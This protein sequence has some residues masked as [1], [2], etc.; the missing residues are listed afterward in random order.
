MLSA[1]TVEILKRLSSAELK[2]FGDFINSPYHNSTASLEKIYKIV[3]KAR[4]DYSSPALEYKN[5]WKKMFPHEEYKEKRIKNLYADFS[6]ILKKFIGYEEIAN[7]SYELDL[8]TAESLSAK[9]LFDASAKFIKKSIAKHDTGLITDHIKLLYNQ[10]INIIQRDNFQHA[11]AETKEQDYRNVL[12]VISESMI[13]RFLRI[14][15]TEAYSIAT[16]EAISSEKGIMIVDA[17]LNVFDMEKFLETLKRE[18]HKY[19][20]YLKINYMLYYHMKSDI[21]EEQ[22]YDLKKEIFNIIHKVEK[23]EAYTFI[24]RTIDLILVKMVRSD[25]KYYRDILDFANLF[26]ELKIF[27]DDSGNVFTIGC[28]RDAFMPAIILKEYEWAENFVYEYAPYLA[29]DTRESELNY[30]LG[31]LSFKKGKFEESLNYLNKLKLVHLVQKISI[32]FYYLMN[33][34]EL[35]AY[36]TALSSVQTLRQYYN[37]NKDMPEI[38]TVNFTESLK[39][40]QEI[41][42][43]EM[44]GKKI[45]GFLYEIAKN[46]KNFNHRQYILEKMEK[47]L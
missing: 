43:C 30:C 38:F 14:T 18:N 6:I 17:F 21:N 29:E 36:E 1:T 16:E 46:G 3:L 34:I 22:L 33:Y 5:I 28:F 32:R 25:R 19:Y 39:Y 35:K 13:T 37:D 40:F 47:L 42:K 4:P 27:P 23:W 2:R 11:G 31:I 26:R 12:T 44:E 8:L 24:F 15:Y 7:K 45:D 9:N 20:S 10:R 41:I